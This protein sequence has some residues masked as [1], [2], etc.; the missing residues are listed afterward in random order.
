MVRYGID[1]VR[2]E[3]EREQFAVYPDS[4]LA[5]AYLELSKE[6]QEADEQL[7]RTSARP[8]PGELT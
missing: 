4:L 1:L 7:G 5:Q 3:V 6:D 2:R 8:T